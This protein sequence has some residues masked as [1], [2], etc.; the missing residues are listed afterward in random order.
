MKKLLLTTAI[1]ATIG[2]QQPAFAREGEDHEKHTHS[3]KQVTVTMKPEAAL[4]ALQDG[5]A[6]MADTVSEKNREEMF[7]DG[8][9]MEKWHEEVSV[10]QDATTSLKQHATT[11]PDEKKKRLES[12]LNQL[13]KLLDDFHMATHNKDA[14]KA[15]AEVTKAKGALKLIEVNIK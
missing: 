15:Q 4:K 8:P 2:F 14:A 13:L 5:I 9:I 3:E 10:I 1:L 7:A 12:S 6:M 11:L